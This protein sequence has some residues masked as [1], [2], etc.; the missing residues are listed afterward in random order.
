MPPTDNMDPD[1]IL[2]YAHSNEIRAIIPTRDGELQYFADCIDYLKENGVDV[3]VAGPEAVRTCLDKKKF[4]DSLSGQ[5][6]VYPIDTFNKPQSEVGKHWVVKERFGSGSK[7]M[8]IDVSLERAQSQ[9]DQFE[10]PICQPYIE[11]QEYSIDLYVS[12]FG[13]PMGCVVRTRDVLLHGESQVTTTV[14]RPD[15]VKLC[16]ETAIKI[17]LVGH[18]VFQIIE[19]QDKRLQIVECNCRFG[20]A[21]TLSIAAGL[22]SFYWFFRECMGDELSDMVFV[23]SPKGLRLVRYAADKIFFK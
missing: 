4:Y 8:L 22:D 18:A 21:S 3:L 1:Q 10:N 7:K 9:L 12:Q 5:D 13:V 15:I 17:G 2:R 16:L 19:D 23:D 20:G 14:Y 6:G 11:G